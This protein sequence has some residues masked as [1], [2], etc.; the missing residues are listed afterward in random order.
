MASLKALA[1]VTSEA[2]DTDKARRKR[3]CES[4]NDAGP[5]KVQRVEGADE[6]PEWKKENNTKSDVKEESAINIQELARMGD[7]VERYYDQVF[8]PDEGAEMED[9]YVHLHVNGLAVVSTEA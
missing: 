4:A 5:S 8:Q 6:K 1:S 2:P 7:V 3:L 9:F